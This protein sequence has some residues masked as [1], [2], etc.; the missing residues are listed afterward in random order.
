MRARTTRMLGATMGSCHN[1]RPAPPAPLCLG[2]APAYS[3]PL[4]ELV[5]HHFPTPPVLYFVDLPTILYF[6]FFTN[7][8]QWRTRTCSIWLRKNEGVFLKSENKRTVVPIQ[9]SI[10]TGHPQRAVKRVFADQSASTCHPSAV[11]CRT[12]R[13]TDWPLSGGFV[14]LT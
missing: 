11:G 7:Q 1:F 6:P 10:G 9:V 5:C 14:M 13:G 3:M 4:L 8:R 12:F 2:C